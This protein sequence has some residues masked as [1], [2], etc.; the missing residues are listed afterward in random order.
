MPHSTQSR[1]LNF[2]AVLLPRCNL[3]FRHLWQSR[4]VPKKS[5][6]TCAEGLNSQRTNRHSAA[7]CSITVQGEGYLGKGVSRILV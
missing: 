3:C 1:Y 7:P 2:Q 6:L 5:L 4:A